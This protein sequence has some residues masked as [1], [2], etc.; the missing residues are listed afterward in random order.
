MTFDFL[1]A[2]DIRVNDER[3]FEIFWKSLPQALKDPLIDLLQSA[4]KPILQTTF[5]IGLAQGRQQ[6]LSLIEERLV[7]RS[8]AAKEKLDA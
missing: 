1:D 3:L 5:E 2:D 6:I 4:A 7:E 8:L